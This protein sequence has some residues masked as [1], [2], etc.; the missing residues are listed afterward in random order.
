M[1]TALVAMVVVFAVFFPLLLDEARSSFRA[2]E[3]GPLPRLCVGEQLISAE[4]NKALRKTFKQ[5]SRA[6]PRQTRYDLLTSAGPGPTGPGAALP[7][8]RP[9]TPKNPPDA[10]EPA[11]LVSVK[12]T[13]RHAE[14]EPKLPRNLRLYGVIR[15]FAGVRA[16]LKGAR[17]QNLHLLYMYVHVYSTPHSLSR[18]ALRSSFGAPSRRI[19]FLIPQ[20]SSLFILI[21]L[22]DS[23]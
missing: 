10:E 16:A 6:A 2:H 20:F 15:P 3:Q 12:G 4:A 11:K 5:G 13:F 8:T 1:A 22:Q 14:I 9:Q 7:R 23:H 19:V 21:N 18:T 17:R